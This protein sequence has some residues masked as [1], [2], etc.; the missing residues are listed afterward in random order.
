MLHQR[1]YRCAVVEEKLL[2][3]SGLFNIYATRARVGPCRGPVADA[4]FS[5]KVEE[6]CAA[7]DSF[8]AATSTPSILA[9]APRRARV[10]TGHSRRRRGAYS[11]PGR[12]PSANPRHRLHPRFIGQYPVREWHDRHSH[13]LGHMPFTAEGYAAIGTALSRAVFQLGRRPV[14]VIAL[15]CDNTLWQGVCGEDGPQ[16]VVVSEPFRRLQE[17]MLSQAQAGVLLVLCSKNNESDALAVF[18]HHAGMLLRREHL[19]GWR[20][21]WEDKPENLRALAATLNVGLDSFVFFDDNPLECATVRAGCPE[22]TVLQLP[23]DAERIPAFLENVWIF[24]RQTTPRGKTGSAASGIGPTRSGRN[25]GPPRPRCATSSTGLQLR[26]EVT[27]ATEDLLE[28]VA[29]LTTRTN[30]F[31]FTSIR[32]STAEIRDLLKSSATCLVTCVSDRFGDYGLVGRHSL[33]GRGRWLC[34]G[35]CAPQLPGAGQ[36]RGA[37]HGRGVGA[38]GRC[39]REIPST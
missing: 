26:I 30:Q 2:A 15:D 13:Q 11:R 38:G 9:V 34:G 21:N 24:D 37:R 32:R 17:F 25:S 16:G 27:E 23:A 12:A 3:G 35:K 28:R 18:D 10:R 22:V 14:K 29:Q 6:F 31:N 7:L 33:S 1:G 39:A 36:R 4:E 5:R 19:A 20:I 8:A